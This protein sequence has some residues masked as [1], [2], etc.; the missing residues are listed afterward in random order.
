MYGYRATIAANYIRNW[1]KHTADCVVAFAADPIRVEQSIARRFADYHD[2]C[3]YLRGEIG[4]AK[5][6]F[7]NGTW[8][9]FVNVPL[10]AEQKEQYAS[11]DIEDND[12]WDGLAAYGEKGYKFSLTYNAGNANWMAT[13]TAQAD[14][15]KNEGYAV[16]GFANDPYSAA[17]VLL[18]KVSCVLPDVWKDFKPLPQDSIG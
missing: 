16:T 5:K 15:G 10:S 9:G 4:V 7:T 3:N 2:G 17:R 14:S 12:V 1:A 8:K 11:W 6:D 13:Y 18:F